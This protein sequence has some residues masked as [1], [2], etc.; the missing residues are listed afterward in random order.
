MKM[1]K[2]KNHPST[3]LRILTKEGYIFNQFAKV[4]NKPG[5]FN[6]ATGFNIF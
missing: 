6:N 5:D 2:C 3:S 4:K 1:I